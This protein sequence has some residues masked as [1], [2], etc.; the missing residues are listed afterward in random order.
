MAQ[1]LL[2]FYHSLPFFPRPPPLFSL[3][4]APSSGIDD[5]A[6]SSDDAHINVRD[7]LASQFSAQTPLVFYL[8][9]YVH[10]RHLERQTSP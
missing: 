6:A 3:Q 4:F 7:I 9:F 2:S 10:V 5:S 8:P 1:S